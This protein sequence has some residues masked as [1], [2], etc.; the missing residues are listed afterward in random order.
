VVH[1]RRTFEVQFAPR[2]NTELMRCEKCD[3]RAEIVEPQREATSDPDALLT[4]PGMIR[5]GSRIFRSASL[6]QDCTSDLISE[7]INRCRMSVCEISQSRRP[8]PSDRPECWL[9]ILNYKSLTNQ[10]TPSFCEG[11]FMSRRLGKKFNE[12]PARGK[13]GAATLTLKTTSL[14]LM[15]ALEAH[16]RP[17]DFSPCRFR[18]DTLVRAGQGPS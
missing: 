17:A 4:H 7:P 2:A 18:Q 12:P 8:G 13:T 1:G 3:C 5:Q 10:L 15:K 9:Q 6:Q 14:C 11:N 16:I